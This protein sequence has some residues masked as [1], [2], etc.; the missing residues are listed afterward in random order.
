MLIDKIG[1]TP[2][3][4]LD[5]NYDGTIDCYVYT[6]TYSQLYHFRG[7]SRR[8]RTSGKVYIYTGYSR[9]EFL[10]MNVPSNFR[11]STDVMVLDLT[12]NTNNPNLLMRQAQKVGGKYRKNI[13]KCLQQYDQDFS[14]PWNRTDASLYT[15]W[16]AHNIFSPFDR[17][18]QD[19]DFDNREENRGFFHY[20][21][22]AWN[23]F[24]DKFWSF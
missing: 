11:Q 7:R 3:Y 21:S 19:V 10:S 15:E 12:T 23:R 13:I 17:S 20:V 6:Y 4:V 8:V 1:F 24:W 16:D 9:A 2:S 5:T 22:K 14:T 18:A